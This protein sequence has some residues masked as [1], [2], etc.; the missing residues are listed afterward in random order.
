[1]DTV[2]EL[3]KKQDDFEK[4][5]AAQEVKFFSLNRETKVCNVSHA[6]AVAEACLCA[7][8]GV[9]AEEEGRGGSE[10]ERGRGEG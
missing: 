5:L 7:G 3:L 1:M 8:G 10:E 6:E 9:G 2:E 4:T